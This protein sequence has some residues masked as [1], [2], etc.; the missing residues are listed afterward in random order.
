MRNS[1]QTVNQTNSNREL[2]AQTKIKLPP[3]ETQ[4]QIVVQINVEMVIVE[5]KKSKYKSSNR[6]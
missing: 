6:K 4:Q 1:R 5:L 3:L 2:L